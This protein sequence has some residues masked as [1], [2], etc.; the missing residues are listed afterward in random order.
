MVQGN[1]LL[2]TR[3]M[4]SIA[5]LG[6]KG[7]GKEPSQEPEKTQLYGESSPTGAVDFGHHMQPDF[8]QIGC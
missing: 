2:Q 7:P 1:S 8:S 5:S 6:L 3:G 4:G